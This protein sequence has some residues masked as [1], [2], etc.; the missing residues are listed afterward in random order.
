MMRQNTVRRNV[1]RGRLALCLLV[2]VGILAP[3]SGVRA[4]QTFDVGISVAPVLFAT[5]QDSNVLLCFQSLDGVAQTLD[6][7]DTF[8]FLF[9][10]SVGTITG[11]GAIDVSAVTLT[12][13]NFTAAVTSTPSQRVVL[14]YHQLGATQVLNYGDM[15]CVTVSF[16]AGAAGS[17]S[18]SL[19]T[20][21][22]RLTNAAL[23]LAPVHVVSFAVAGTPGPTGPTG[24]TGATGATGPTGATGATG[25]T[26]PTGPTGA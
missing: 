26:G 1:L 20:R 9:P 14:T 24:V 16:I 19:E 4:Q 10:A 13:A 2:L 22:N 25:P 15:A 8:T 12:P 21:F 5:G 7:G 18:I 3:L 17:A 23:P 6:D 11:V